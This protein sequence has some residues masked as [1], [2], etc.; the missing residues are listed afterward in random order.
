MIEKLQGERFSNGAI[1]PA[2]EPTLIGHPTNRAQQRDLEQAY[3]RNLAITAARL[4]DEGKL[5][6]EDLL[7]KRELHRRS[8]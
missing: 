6:M 3:Q 2:E 8:R 7:P 5:T 1:L 4:I